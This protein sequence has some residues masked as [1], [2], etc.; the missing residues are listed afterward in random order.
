MIGAIGIDTGIS[1]GGASAAT[2]SG[3]ERTRIRLMQSLG[4]RLDPSDPSVVK[5]TAAQMLSELFFGPLLAEA[6][7]LP[8][9]KTMFDGG[10]TESVFG[11]RLDQ[12]VADTV[13][14]SNIGLVEDLAQRFGGRAGGTTVSWDRA[15]QVRLDSRE[16]K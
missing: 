6:R 13:A 8:F 2:P 4:R 9:G 5:E 3:A 12:Q 14:A 16:A 15:L 10:Q 7:K 1:T 11:E